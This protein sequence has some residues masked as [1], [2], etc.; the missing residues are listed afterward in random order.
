MTAITYLAAVE[1]KRQEIRNDGCTVQFL[2]EIEV[3][4]R[5]V[6]VNGRATQGLLTLGPGPSVVDFMGEESLRLTS[7]FG[8]HEQFRIDWKLN[9]HGGSDVD[10]PPASTHP[11]LHAWA[12]GEIVGFGSVKDNPGGGNWVRI[13]HNPGARFSVYSKY[14]HLNDVP[15]FLTVGEWVNRGQIVG[16]MG[17]SGEYVRPKR[18]DGTG[19]EHLHYSCR[20]RGN[21]IDPFVFLVPNLVYPE[22]RPP[23]NPLYVPGKKPSDWQV[24]NAAFDLV[25]P[26]HVQDTSVEVLDEVRIS[27]S[28][29]EKVL[30]EDWIMRVKR[31]WR[32]PHTGMGDL[33]TP[34]PSGG[35][36]KEEYEAWLAQQ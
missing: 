20:Y 15:D 6:D 16:V 8:S 26:Y 33:L 19:G 3:F 12:P 18:A 11:D 22:I 10:N 29:D 34:P 13:L 30:Y 1:E 14:S 4:D 36:T 5:P 35:I 24:L 17:N 9:P 25:N 32:V 2:G 28:P 23:V 27:F 31:P 7:L 21:L